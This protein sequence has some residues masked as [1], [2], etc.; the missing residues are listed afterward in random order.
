M[1]LSTPQRHAIRH[2]QQ[3]LSRA[4]LSVP[5]EPLVLPALDSE[6]ALLSSA[7]VVPT[8]PTPSDLGAIHLSYNAPKARKFTQE[9]IDKQ[10]NYVNRQTTLTAIVEHPVGAIVEYP[11]TGDGP[12]EIIGHLF[13]VEPFHPHPKGDFQYSLGGSHGGKPNVKCG[14][15]RNEDE[16]PAFCT[17]LRTECRGIKVCSAGTDCFDEQHSYV[18]SRSEVLHG[19]GSTSGDVNLD[20]EEE[21]FTKTLAF[22]CALHATGCDFSGADEHDSAEVKPPL[23][24]R[25]RKRRQPSCLGTLKLVS[26][27]YGRF[28]VQCEYFSE[29]NKSHLCIRDLNEYNIDYLNALLNDDVGKISHFETG[30][31]AAGFGPLV[32]CSFRASCV[33]QKQ[34]C[35]YWHRHADGSL[36]RGELRNALGF[37]LS[38][39]N[40]HSHAPPLPTKTPESVMGIFH[41][42]LL[43]LDWKLADTTPRK[44]ML[45]S[46]FMQGL[47][48]CLQWHSLI[49]PSLSHLHPSLGNLDRVRRCITLLRNDFF[50]S[51]TGFAGAK[52]IHQ[53]HLKAPIDARYVRAVE[54]HLLDD[55]TEFQLIVCMSKAMSDHLMQSR[56]VTIDTSFKRS[57]DFD[58]FEIETWD[59]ANMRSYVSARAFITSQSGDAHLILFRRIFEIA[60]LDTNQHVL[61]RHIDGTGLEVWVADAHKGQALGLGKFC[62]YLCRERMDPVP[63][64]PT[65]RLCDLGPYEHL[66]R[67]YKAC[68]VHFKRNIHDLRHH[69]SKETQDAMLSLASAEPHP[70][71]N[72]AL[73]VI[74]KGGKKAKAWLKD[75]QASKFMLPALYQPLSKIPIQIW[76][77]APTSTNGNEQAHRSINRDG[78]NMTLLG[79]IMRGMQYDARVATS[80]LLYASTGIYSRDQT[81]THYRRITSALHKKNLCPETTTSKERCHESKS[82]N[83]DTSAAAP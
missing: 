11:Q 67:C 47:R 9:E 3:I 16:T 82:F 73:E 75:K 66:Q 79:A 8:V 36:R 51:G 59:A 12:E 58:E 52:L 65:R 48:Q 27:T 22:F 38:A 57:H 15:L 43:S 40:P 19:I 21:V 39:V 63:D 20:A 56:R 26:D 41:A 2:A 18:A 55:G 53:E 46:G 37:S 31:K 68:I 45:D 7:A 25:T 72:K 24:L 34:L 80:S 70:D 14:L 49:D 78:T 50:P 32:A 35:P 5:L 23:P 30:A 71:F 13:H 33:E 29:D 42:L 10:L 69:T 54:S 17:Y 64:E 6:R 28:G 44:I 1:N 61:F 81:S 77:S 76:K 74:Q 4:G 83:V 60:R 62:Q